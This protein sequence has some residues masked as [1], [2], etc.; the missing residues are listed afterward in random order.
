MKIKGN[1]KLSLSY[2]FRMAGS[3]R[4]VFTDSCFIIVSTLIISVLSLFFTP[5]IVYLLEEKAA[6]E[7]ILASIVLFISGFIL[8]SAMQI[9]W[10]QISL[11][12]RISIRMEIMHSIH[13]KYSETSYP[14]LL[15]VR[16]QEAFKRAAETTSSN[17]E[18][19]EHIWVVLYS[20]VTDFLLILFYLFVLRNMPLPLLILVM[21]CSIIGFYFTKKA[22]DYAFERRKERQKLGNKV[23]YM[24]SLAS[25]PDYAKDIR[26]FGLKDWLIELREK[27]LKLFY[28]FRG[29]VEQKVL[30]VD[31]LNVIFTLLRNGLAYAYLLHLVFHQGLTAG[32]FILYFSAFNNISSQVESLLT[33]GRNMVTQCN[34]LAELTE[35]LAWPEEFNFAESA[36]G[37]MANESAGYTIELKNVS[38]TYPEA[39]TP[40]ICRLDLV[41]HTGEKL[42]IVGLNGAGKTTLIRLICGFLDPTEGEVLVNGVDI[43]QLNRRK[44][45]EIFSV[46]LQHFS[47][48]AGDI[49]QNILQGLAFDEGKY[50]RVLKESGLDRIVERLEDGDASLLGVDIFPEAVALSGGEMQ[51]LMLARALYRN[52]PLLVLDEPTA[53]LD[54]IAESEMYEK[55]NLLCANKSSIFISHRLAST[56][57]CDR[58]LM[59][60]EGR[61]IESGTHTELMAKEGKYKQLFDVQSQYYKADSRKN[62]EQEAVP[63]RKEAEYE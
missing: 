1:V 15:N 5:S 45:Y 26:L 29:E 51:T 62:A 59:M 46:V 42:A 10:E 60:E 40:T 11:F 24:N 57:F 18:A 31:L 34:E 37:P 4:R 12:P 48:L 44:Y 56:R 39:K 32:R 38:Y 9:F 19:S 27:T 36:P 50:G 23:Q 20:L 54:P 28:Q 53:A 8:F 25:S 47:L 63:E 17:H 7:H 43:R 3:E 2:M 6:F 55:Y 22:Q 13:A 61:I 33:H 14:N 30:L 52:R 35:F 58:I 21:A 16:F 41:W 49:K